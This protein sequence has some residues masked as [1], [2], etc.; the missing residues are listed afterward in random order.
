M[1]YLQLQSDKELLHIKHCV[2]PPSELNNTHNEF[3]IKSLHA[4]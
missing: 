4:Q 2:L 3:S 1:T